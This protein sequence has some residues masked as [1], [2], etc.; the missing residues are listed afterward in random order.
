[1]PR[2]AYLLFPFLMDLAIAASALILNLRAQDLGASAFQLG[3][4]GFAWGVPFALF[5]ALTGTLMRR[6]PRRALVLAG[7]LLFALSNALSALAPSTALLLAL[8][9]LSGAGCALFWPVF[10]TYLH[11]PDSA[12]THARMGRFNLGWTA[13]L[14]LGSAGGGYLYKGMGSAGAFLAVAGLTVLHAALLSAML[15]R[16]EGAPGGHAGEDLT[17]EERAVP[18]ARRR[19]YLA[20]TWVANFTVAFS[21]AA[22][23]TLFPRLGRTRG[24]GDGPIGVLMA[25]MTAAQGVSFVL[26]SNTR[27][28]HYR[29][30]PLAAAQACVVGGLIASA[31]GDGPAAFAAGFAMIGLGRGVTYTASLFYGLDADAAQG[32]NTGLHEAII[33]SSMFLGPLLAGASATGGGSLRLPFLLSG[34]LIGAALLIEAR[35]WRMLPGLAVPASG[36]DFVEMGK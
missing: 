17:P 23:T 29:I 14:M 8:V 20:L 32:H 5:S 10:E 13:G 6:F 26:L 7:P 35:L 3:L 16:E 19:G 36:K 4:L 11:V 28:W 25:A 9:T 34:A 33:G 21:S 15:G 22:A 1:M 12:E 30:A 27:R 31:M 2:A 24:R 18:A